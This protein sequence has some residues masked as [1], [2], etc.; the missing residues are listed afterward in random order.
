MLVRS[1][2]YLYGVANDPTIAM[3]VMIDFERAR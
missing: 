2:G 3:N 1:P